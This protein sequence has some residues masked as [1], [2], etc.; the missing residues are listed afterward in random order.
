MQIKKNPLHEVAAAVNVVFSGI[1]SMLNVMVT[2]NFIE[3]SDHIS[4]SHQSLR[5][6]VFK[7]IA[8][9]CAVICRCIEH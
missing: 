2:I 6:A 9:L 4:S 3:H 1:M 7:H 8:L 5:Q